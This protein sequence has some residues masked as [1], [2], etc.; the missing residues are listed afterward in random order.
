MCNILLNGL[1]C[2][3]IIS[4]VDGQFELL[5][6]LATLCKFELLDQLATLCNILLNGL[7]LG[8]LACMFILHF[9]YISLSINCVMKIQKKHQSSWP[10]ISNR[11]TKSVC[12]KKETVH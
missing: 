5:D 3:E 4:A 10:N 12:T 11:F 7:Y 8:I 2:F 1:Y 9:I 6:Q